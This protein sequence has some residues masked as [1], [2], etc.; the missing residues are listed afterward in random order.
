V[1]NHCR[2]E[3]EARLALRGT[4]YFM[5]EGDRVDDPDYA[6][7]NDTEVLAG[8]VVAP[9]LDEQTG[10][11]IWL[12]YHDQP[13]FDFLN[14]AAAFVCSRDQWQPPDK[15]SL[16]RF[17]EAHPQPV[18]FEDQMRAMLEDWTGTATDFEHDSPWKEMED[19]NR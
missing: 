19:H 2:T 4:A 11:A 15:T 9:T 16:D 10:D 6:F 3:F 13:L 8:L 5:D 1:I 18:W 7:M 17:F 12:D 14:G